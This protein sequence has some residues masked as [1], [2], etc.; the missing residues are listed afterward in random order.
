MEAPITSGGQFHFP[1]YFLFISGELLAGHLLCS[2]T[3]KSFLPRDADGLKSTE[4]TQYKK[5]R[6]YH[7]TFN[8]LKNLLSI[9]RLKQ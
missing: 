9:S 6:L 3:V 8:L 7:T 5:H 2:K 4:C 1:F